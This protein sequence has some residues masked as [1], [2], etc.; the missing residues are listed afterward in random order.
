MKVQNNVF[1]QIWDIWGHFFKKIFFM[2]LFSPFLWDSYYMVVGML[3]GIPVSE[4][5]LIILYWWF[6]FYYT[7]WISSIDL[8]HWFFCLLTQVCCWSPLMNFYFLKI[9]RLGIYFY[10]CMLDLQY[11]HFLWKA[12]WFIYTY[13]HILF[14]YG[15]L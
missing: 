8:I 5:L 12:K 13:I 1:H 6:F 15:L 3:D 4:A 11:V 10:W 7:Y 9:F 2:P 14:N